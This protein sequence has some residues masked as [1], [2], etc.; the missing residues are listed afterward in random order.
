[1]LGHVVTVDIWEPG[2]QHAKTQVLMAGTPSSFSLLHF[3]PL[4]LI[5]Q[6]TQ[7]TIFPRIIRA[8]D[9]ICMEKA[10]Y[11]LLI[12]IIIIITAVP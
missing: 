8:F 10:H 3:F 5:V 11:K 6:N 1:M 2:G 12:I 9:H 7:T 4:P